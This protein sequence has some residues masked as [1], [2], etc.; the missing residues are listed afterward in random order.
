MCHLGIGGGEVINT[1]A[2]YNWWMFALDAAR[3]VVMDLSVLGM[4]IFF[5]VTHHFRVTFNCAKRESIH[6]CRKKRSKS[7]IV[8]C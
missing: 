2:H 8:K 3:G 4:L 7:S 5:E 1:E 6:L